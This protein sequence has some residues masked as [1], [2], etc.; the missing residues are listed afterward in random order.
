MP[1]QFVGGKS[2]TSESAS[3]SVPLTGLTGGIA[4]APAA[5]DMVIVFSGYPSTT[6]GT[7]GITAPSVHT[8]VADLYSN[9]STVDTNFDASYFFAASTPETSVTV[10]GIA[11]AS[12]C[13]I[14]VFRGVDP[15]TPLDA[16]TTT[17]TGITGF[18]PNPPAITPVT[19]GA[20]VVAGGMLAVGLSI[21]TPTNAMPAGYTGYSVINVNAFSNGLVL[22]GAY[23]AGV[24]AGV[25]EDPGAFNNNYASGTGFSWAAVTMVLRPIGGN[26]KVWNGSAWVAEPARH[27][28]GSAWVTKPV[29]YWNGSSW[30][31]TPY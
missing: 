18:D 1:I 10:T 26:I 25:A 27:W 22:S 5:G 29:K 4:T 11:N 28:N 23:K 15:T 19:A 6:N 31:K 2:A 13:V 24:S 17:I 16:T 9:G 30:V 20:V 8:K 21:S 14:L 12:G 7:P 3:Y